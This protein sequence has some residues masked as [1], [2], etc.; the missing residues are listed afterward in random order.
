MTAQAL[1]ARGST[2]PRRRRPR[3]LRVLG[4]E[5]LV[6]GAFLALLLIGATLGPLL[7][8]VDP[9]TT[10]LA[11]RF[12]GP[13]LAA[14]LGTDAFGRDLLARILHGARI[15]LAGAAAVVLGETLLGMS[16]GLLAG[17]GHARLDAAL[18][19]LIDAVLALPSLVMALA[20]V[21]VLGK[22]MPNL[23]VAL[24]VTGW[25]WYAR[26]YRS[27]AIQQRA[28]DYVLAAHACGCSPSR[29][30][31]RHIGPNIIGPALV[32]STVNLG[33]AILGL[34]SMSFL[35]L[36]VQPPA[37]EWGAMVNDARLNFQTDPW[38]IVVPGAAIGLTV[39]A[40][41]IL[42]DALRDLADPHA[43]R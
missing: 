15:S 35:G 25:P 22:S 26:L 42:G 30:I 6:A 36:G 3:V 43:Q 17:A 20:I 38:P 39:I 2:A 29:I 19:R 8:T 10:Q 16:I 31:W 41:N 23:I 27:F 7:W 14:P 21:G 9:D 32:L 11:R 40:V 33:G 1:E 24:I 13:S 4:T 34:A 12:E 28:Q 5:G 37:S 18:G